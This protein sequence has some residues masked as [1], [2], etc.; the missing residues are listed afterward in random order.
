MQL[1][2][3][4]SAAFSVTDSPDKFKPLSLQSRSSALGCP[5]RSVTHQRLF[6]RFLNLRASVSAEDEVKTS[7]H[8]ILQSR[9]AD[10]GAK[11]E[12]EGLLKAEETERQ[13]EKYLL[14]GLA[15]IAAT[16]FAGYCI[17][18]GQTPDQVFAALSTIDPKQVHAQNVFSPSAA[19]LTHRPAR[20]AAA[21]CGAATLLPSLPR[22]CP[23]LAERAP[24]PSETKARKRE[25]FV[26]PF[27]CDAH[28]GPRSRRGTAAYPRF[29]ACAAADAARQRRSGLPSARP[30]P[31]AGAG[32]QRRPR[33]GP[34]HP[35]VKQPPAP[36][37]LGSRLPP[38]P[39][40][41]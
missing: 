33:R 32:G 16:A 4:N 11:V 40:L 21:P 8:N 6:T 12:D 15:G 31:P 13:I 39:P 41:H 10:A 28:P 26:L 17:G 27:A 20:L 18:T 23:S 30:P 9:T 14:V 5:T 37:R 22:H 19:P 29:L 2:F 36:P 24:P 3:R 1:S 7:S 38:A 34:R 25:P 35:R